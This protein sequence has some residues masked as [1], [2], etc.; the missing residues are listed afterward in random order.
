[1]FLIN[2]L[3]EFKAVGEQGHRELVN[4]FWTPA[5]LPNIKLCLSSRPWTVFAD[6]FGTCTE[7]V[8]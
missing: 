2:S 5:T 3:D 1:M 8:L 7:R 4:T 6:A